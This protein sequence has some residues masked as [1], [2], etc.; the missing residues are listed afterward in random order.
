[1]NLYEPESNFLIGYGIPEKGTYLDLGAAHPIRC[2]LTSFLRDAGWR[3]L[4]IDGNQDYQN[5]WADAGFGAHFVCAVLSDQPTA[6]FCVHENSFT[7]RI[8]PCEERDRPEQWG[9]LRTETRSCVPL[10]HLLDVHDIGQIDVLS[11]DL[12]GHELQ[13]L[14]TLDFARHTPTFVIVEFVTQGEGINCDVANYLVELGYRLIHM[15]SS[16]LIFKRE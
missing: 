3:G 15:T 12:E 4:A 5:D 7:S 16:N 11:C 13:V 9:I 1:M 2:S 6:R 8:S 14:K 10:E